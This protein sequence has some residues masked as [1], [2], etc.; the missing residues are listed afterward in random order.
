MT[1]SQVTSKSAFAVALIGA[2]LVLNSSPKSQAIASTPGAE[3]DQQLISSAPM[4][5]EYNP[6]RAAEN[7][8]DVRTDELGYQYAVPLGTPEG[9]MTD[10][11]P[12]VPPPE[13]L[14]SA[15]QQKSMRQQTGSSYGVATG[16]CG[17][18]WI[19]LDSRTQFSTGYVINLFWGFALAHTWNVAFVSSIDAGS[20]NL[21][22]IPM[23]ASYTWSTS[24]SYDEIALDGQYLDAA[25]GGSVK[26]VLGDCVS[27]VPV[28]SIQF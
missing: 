18:S 26:T 21:S 5:F 16:N 22:G 2:L 27:A 19:S 20:Y 6:Q 10:A 11:T 4:T 9:S 17:V 7:G 14:T 15:Q 28:A 3:T 23:V 13:R 24:S 25:A 8:F 1:Q 12:R